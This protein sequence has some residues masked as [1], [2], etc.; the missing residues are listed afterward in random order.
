VGLRDGQLRFVV[1]LDRPRDV[2]EARRI[3]FTEHQLMPEQ[4]ADS[5]VPLK[6]MVTPD[7]HRV[8][9]AEG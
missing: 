1:S 5:S 7:R 2:I 6:R 3:L 9:A 4:V 8:A